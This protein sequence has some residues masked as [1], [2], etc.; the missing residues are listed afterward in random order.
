MS[1]GE[2]REAVVRDRPV[3][4]GV[5]RSSL[6]AFGTTGP[7]ESSSACSKGAVRWPRSVK[8]GGGSEAI[9]LG[10]TIKRLREPDRP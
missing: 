7:C 1:N 6:S 2:F 3:R 9:G 4:V 5:G 10:G 8:I